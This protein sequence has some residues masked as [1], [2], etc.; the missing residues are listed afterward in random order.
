M[1]L[2]ITKKRLETEIHVLLDV[3]MEQ[4]EARLIR[5]QVDRNATV[6]RNDDGVFHNSASWLAVHIDELK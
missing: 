3:A 5:E 6:Q 2:L 4:S 1:V